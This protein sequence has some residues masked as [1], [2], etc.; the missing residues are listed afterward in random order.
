M[1][2]DEISKEIQRLKILYNMQGGGA[3]VIREEIEYHE[4]EILKLTDSDEKTKWHKECISRLSEYY[5]I[6]KSQRAEKETEIS[7]WHDRLEKIT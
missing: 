4:N 5:N 3:I 1:T 2:K 7:Y 6:I